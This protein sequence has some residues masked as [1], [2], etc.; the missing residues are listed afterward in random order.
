MAIVHSNLIIHVQPLLN[1]VI[2]TIKIH[3][4]APRVIV[5]QESLMEHIISVLIQK[6]AQKLQILVNVM[7]W[8]ALLVIILAKFHN[9]QYKIKIIVIILDK[10]ISGQQNFVVTLIQHV[11]MQ[12][13]TT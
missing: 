6:N 8:G 3:K 4:D 7:K 10:M 5:R 11:L 2:T 9:V 12:T 1:A 13:K